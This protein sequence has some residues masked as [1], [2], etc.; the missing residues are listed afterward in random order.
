MTQKR[1]AIVTGGARGIGRAIVFALARQG[2]R[3]AALDIDEAR[4]Q[5]LEAL[6]RDDGFDVLAEKLDITDGA[7]LT[8]GIER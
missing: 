7:A 2:R 4:L 1:L 3:V 8:A 5:E 6:A